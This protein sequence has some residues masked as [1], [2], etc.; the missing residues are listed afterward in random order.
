VP[1]FLVVD[2]DTRKTKVLSEVDEILV[3][4]AVL[5]DKGVTSRNKNGL[6]GERISPGTT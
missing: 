2:I 4:I 6:L 3:R 5:L 1:H